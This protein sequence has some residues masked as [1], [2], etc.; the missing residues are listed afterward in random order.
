MAVISFIL[1]IMFQAISHTDSIM[2][3]NNVFRPTEWKNSLILC[4]RDNSVHY[5]LWTLALSFSEMCSASLLIL[6]TLS[7]LGTHVHHLVQAVFILLFPI[8]FGIQR[9]KR[10]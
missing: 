1:F 10:N 5:A 4:A 9:V 8:T 6:D 2:C 3:M 7:A